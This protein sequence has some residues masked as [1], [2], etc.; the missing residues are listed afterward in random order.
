M[1]DTQIRRGEYLVNFGGCHDCHT[2]KIIT[3]SGP[4]PDKKR[5]L[6]GHP[7]NGRLSDVPKELIG[8]ERWGAVTNNDLTAWV[9]PWGTSFAA[10]LTPD[11]ATGLGSWSAKDFIATMRTGKHLGVG[12]PVLPPMPWFDVGTLNDRDL[13]AIFAYLHSLKSIVNK[14]PQPISPQ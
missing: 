2:P 8:P 13:K 7:E 9:G 11:K 12:R 14:V 5:F 6:S 10:N 1:S 4:A 3:P